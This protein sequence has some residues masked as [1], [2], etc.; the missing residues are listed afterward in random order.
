MDVPDA[1]SPT[2]HRL[3]HR[4][5]LVAGTEQVVSRIEDDAKHLRVGFGQKAIG[6][7]RRL[8]PASRMGVEDGAQP[9]L[10]PYRPRHGLGATGVARPLIVRQRHLGGDT[11]GVKG[12]TRTGDIA[13]SDPDERYGTP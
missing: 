4:R 8:H 6:L 5:S 12:A 2:I 3:D 10:L 7:S 1:V 11:N 13:V 9:G